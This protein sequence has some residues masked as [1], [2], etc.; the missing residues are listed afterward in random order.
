MKSKNLKLK[1][2]NCVT[3]ASGK[4]Y[5]EMTKSAEAKGFYDDG[6]AYVFK[7]D[8][9][10][11]KSVKP[12]HIHIEV[13]SGSGDLETC[14]LRLYSVEVSD[15][16]KEEK[17]SVTVCSNSE[18]ATGGGPN[19][20]GAG[21]NPE[22]DPASPP[23]PLDNRRRLQDTD[24]ESGEA[25]A[26]EAPEEGEEDGEQESDAGAES[27]DGEELDCEKG[28]VTVAKAPS[29]FGNYTKT[30]YSDVAFLRLGFF[31]HLKLNTESMIKMFEE[32]EWLSV[33]LLI[34]WEEQTVSIYVDGEAKLATPFFTKRKQTIQEINTVALY[35]LTPE[36]V[37]RFR[38]LQIC[39][40]I[41]TGGK[42]VCVDNDLC[43]GAT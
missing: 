9:G 4:P 14:D 8:Q 36:S 42:L 16:T 11:L 35:G 5:L 27:Q 15:E 37:S 22:R 7:D 43:S 33:D 31:K 26:E 1:L 20:E 34:D 24:E 18:W 12:A 39:D 23:R 6:L 25:E 17:E 3:G 32:G 30:K 28:T 10:N 19:I 21:A 41:C 29:G 13:Q 40:D 2:T 38:N